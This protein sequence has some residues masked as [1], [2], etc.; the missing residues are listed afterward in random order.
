[1]DEPDPFPLDQGERLRIGE[2]GHL[3]VPLPPI[4][5]VGE[6]VVEVAGMG[7]ELGHP[8]RQLAQVREHALGRPVRV[9]TRLPH[10]VIRRLE[11]E[12]PRSG[13]HLRVLR[14][15]RHPDGTR[16]VQHQLQDR[17]LPAD[18]VV[19]VQMRGEPPH[20]LPELV[21]LHPELD[22]RLVRSGA[23]RGLPGVA[24]ELP[25]PVQ[26]RGHALRGRH[27]R[28]QREVHV[29]PHPHP[30]GLELLDERGVHRPVHEQGRARHDPAP[31]RVE[32]AAAHPRG[33]AVVVGVDD[34]T[35]GGLHRDGSSVRVPWIT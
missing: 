16:E 18:V 9:R 26:E 10:E 8:A 29:Q 32:D 1:V 27:R 22:A 31:V 20:D 17:L 21:D 11:R 7:H 24:G 6:V 15:H 19:R 12:L 34:E 13:P 2:P 23:P 4:A 14:P 30:R 35:A 5:T 3:G 33:E 25:F 28:P